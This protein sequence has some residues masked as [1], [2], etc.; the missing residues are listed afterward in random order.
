MSLSKLSVVCVAVLVM[1]SGVAARQAA[2]Q[3]LTDKDRAEIQ[4]LVAKYAK[5]LSSCASQEYASLFV[6]DGTFISDDFRGPRHRAMY[7]PNGGTLVGRAKLAELV[8]TEEFCLDKSKARA[9]SSAPP[10]AV[11]IVPTAQGA[12][13]TINLAN[14]ARYEDEYVKTAEGWR[15]KTRRVVM[16]PRPPAQPSSSSR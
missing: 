15:F 4:D 7:G 3:A 14:N 1:G 16:P 11:A 5:A 8:E 13:G 12:S 10:P 2:P 6:P 9:Q